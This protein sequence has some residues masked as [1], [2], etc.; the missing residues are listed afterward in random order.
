LLDCSV[1]TGWV[2]HIG[3]KDWDVTVVDADSLTD[4]VQSILWTARNGH[5]S[6]RFGQRRRQEGRGEVA[7]GGDECSL[8]V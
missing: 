3:G 5:A 4:G 8:S 2:S 6:A 7:A 1:Y